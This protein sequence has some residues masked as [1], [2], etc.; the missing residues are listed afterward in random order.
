MG[1]ARFALCELAQHWKVKVQGHQNT[2]NE[3]QPN[4]FCCRSSN[5]HRIF[6]G[7]TF[8]THTL[9]GEDFRGEWPLLMSAFRIYNFNLT[10]TSNDDEPTQKTF[11]HGF[12][13]IDQ[14]PIFSCAWNIQFS[15]ERS[16]LRHVNLWRCELWTQEKVKSKVEGQGKQKVIQMRHCGPLCPACWP[17]L[18]IGQGKTGHSWVIFVTE[19]SLYCLG[20]WPYSVRKILY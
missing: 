7:Q 19:L 1:V 20:V 8:C 4:H 9:S 15:Y 6:C 10:M 2:T 16:E 17:A 12:I 14:G 3:D 11:V 5:R 18:P 13:C